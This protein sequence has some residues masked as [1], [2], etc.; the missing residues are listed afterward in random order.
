MKDSMTIERE[1][2]TLQ[3]FVG[4]KDFIDAVAKA[5][6][7]EELRKILNAG[8][9]SGFSEEQLDESYTYLALSQDWDTLMDMFDDKV[10]ESCSSKLASHGIAVTR[11][12]FDL[13]NEVV[14]SGSDDELIKEILHMEDVDAV[15]EALHRHGYH[16]MTGDFLLLV[17]ENATHFYEDA[18]LT[19]EELK[20]LSGK[21]FYER[22]RRS[23]NLIFTLSTIAGLALGVTSVAEPALLLA[24]AGG[25]SLMF[26]DSNASA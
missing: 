23:V 2:G 24:I 3:E 16:A 22:C 10:F 17:Q 11:D 1:D 25:V 20:E 21:N 19:Q 13:V 14:R 7:K 9:V 12:E 6:S 26:G 5:A 18:V 8:G 15:L 4:G